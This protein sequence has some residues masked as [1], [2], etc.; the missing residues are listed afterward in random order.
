MEI[1]C[2]PHGGT[3]ERLR[4]MLPLDWEYVTSGYWEQGPYHS[5]HIEY[6]LCGTAPGQWMLESIER[7]AE[8]DSVTEEDV[9]AGRLN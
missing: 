3:L 7:N 9:E 4:P 2:D 6:R 1:R 8:L 5:G